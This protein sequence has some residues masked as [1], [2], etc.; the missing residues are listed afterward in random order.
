MVYMHVEFQQLGVG[1]EGVSTL[2]SG[3]QV[4]VIP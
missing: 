2:N 1:M 4:G 3:S